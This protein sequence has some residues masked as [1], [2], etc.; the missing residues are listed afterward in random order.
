MRYLRS[1]GLPM[2]ISRNH[3]LAFQFALLA[4]VPLLAWSQG[5]YTTSFPNTE[6]PISEGGK[7]IRRSAVLDSDWTN[8]PE[9][10]PALVFGTHGRTGDYDDSACI[11]TGTWGPTQTVQATVSS[12]NQD[13]NYIQEVELRL[14][15]P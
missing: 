11:L 15:V 6:N 1:S 13:A 4:L 9:L 10:R 5:T 7:W 12:A 8:C 3:R 14:R 2:F